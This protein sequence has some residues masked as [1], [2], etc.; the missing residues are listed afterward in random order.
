MASIILG[1]DLLQELDE[2]QI[3]N[4]MNI[5]ASAVSRIA[6]LTTLVFSNVYVLSIVMD[7][8]LLDWNSRR[9]THT[10][11]LTQ[12]TRYCIHRV[13]VSWNNGARL[14]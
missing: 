3:S 7:L 1:P 9:S 2:L 10:A 12:F 6:H 11:S 14:G 8:R 4:Y 13:T 5:A